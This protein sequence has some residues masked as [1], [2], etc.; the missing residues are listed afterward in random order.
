LI[1]VSARQIEAIS[2]NG[3]RLEAEGRV[4][5]LRIPI[6]PAPSFEGAR[7]LIIVFTKGM[8]TRD[9]VRG[10]AH[11]VGPET[12]VLTL[13]NGLGNS[14]AIAEVLPQAPILIGMTNWPADLHAPG[15]V[16]SRG[17]GEVRLW[18]ANRAHDP[19]IGRVAEVLNEAGL[20]CTADPQVEV[21]IWEKVAFNAALNSL[22]AATGVSVA[23]VGHGSS[24]RQLARDIAA[25]TL[26]VAEAIGLAVDLNRVEAA[27]D[28]AF[29]EHGGHKPSMLQDIIAG[30]P[31]EIETINGAVVRRA[32]SL[33]LDA[34]TTRILA[35]L[36]R[37]R[38]ASGG[39]RSCT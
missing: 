34:P 16:I 13:Q 3:L 28:H 2:T 37:L 31:T 9:A 24:G 15:H 30:R 10:A 27:F 20:A 5:N 19:A 36:V 39:P 14:D 11:L 33:G 17:S 1:E 21:S 35:D 38:E 23:A 26:A 29:R 32:E 12:R 6:G 8:H 7:E 18:S 25:E 4:L 22:C